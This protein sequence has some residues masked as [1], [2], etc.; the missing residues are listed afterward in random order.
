MNN[1]TGKVFLIGAGPGNPELITVRGQRALDQ[2]DAVVYDNLISEALVIMLPQRVERHYVGKQCD[3]HA[4]SQDKINQLL[5]DLA[6]QGKIV[7]RLKGGDPFTFGRGG[8]EASFLRRNDIEFE[9]VPGVTSG[10]AV[11]AYA[12]I[13]PTDRRLASMVMYV[14]GHKAVNRESHVDWSWVAKSK[15]ATIVIYMG[16][17][18]LPSLVEQLTAN[19]MSADLPAAVIERG[20]F[21][22]QR[23]VTAP[24]SQLPAKATEADI[25]PPAL[26]VLGNVVGLRD[27]I[28]WFANKPLFGKRVMI[29]RPADQSLDLYEELRDLGAEV[30]TYPTIATESDVHENEWKQIES[31]ATDRKWIV[32]TSE[33][34]VRYFLKQYTD[35]FA[36]I[37][38]LAGYKIAAVGFGTARALQAAH[39]QPD[40]VPSKATTRTMADEMVAQ[41]DL[42]HATVI[43]VRGNLGDM[44]IEDTLSKA[45]ADVISL[46]V[47]RTFTPK[48]PENLKAKLMKFPPDYIMFTS[49]SS[50]DGFIENIKPDELKHFARAVIMSIGPTTS[51]VIR[52]HGLR[53]SIEATNHS[54]PGV[55]DELI[56][57]ASSVRPAVSV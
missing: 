23:I 21:S 45:G 26:I 25:K 51:D 6:K 44:Y 11:L 48:W 13:P 9:V 37:R 50:C 27:S 4:L 7:A 31:I 3:V 16:V 22:T 14:T 20:T 43:R 35:H 17:G 30:L 54:I 53:V 46:P 40:F 10:S 2:C 34:S 29:T 38:S 39:I 56:R 55:V 57:H 36:D 12:G 18:E 49:G 32:L 41:L 24:L 8:E 33:N 15:Y 42:Q 28:D 47:Y 5:V 1:T 52:S 19:G